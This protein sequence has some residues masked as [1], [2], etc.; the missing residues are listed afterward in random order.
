MVTITDFHNCRVGNKD[1]LQIVW[2]RDV[3]FETDE[4]AIGGVILL[5]VSRDFEE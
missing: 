5:L 3:S 2:I 1:D 4:K